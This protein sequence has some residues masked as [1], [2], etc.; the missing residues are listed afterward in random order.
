[1][2]KYNTATPQDVAKF[3]RNDELHPDQDIRSILYSH[4]MG[5]PLELETAV[6]ADEEGKYVALLLNGHRVGYHGGV[7]H[8]PPRPT[9]PTRLPSPEPSK[10]EV[11]PLPD[12]PVNPYR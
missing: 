1:M 3:D 10:K 12:F 9:P 8:A 6:P 5:Q 4:A 7:Y 11:K 2:P